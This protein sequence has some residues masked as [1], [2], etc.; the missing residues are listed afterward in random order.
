MLAVIFRAEINRLDE[1]YHQTAKRLQELALR[2]YGC[3]EF[4]A[5]TEGGREVAISYWDS[6]EQIRAWRADP[7]HTAARAM[8]RDRW[9]KSYSVQVAEVLR[10]YEH[11]SSF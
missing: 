3:V 6:E 1:E 4:C 2:D 5:W 9:Y 7:E 8:G 11:P 10:A